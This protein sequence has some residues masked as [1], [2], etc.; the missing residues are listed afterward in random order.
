MEQLV[1]DPGLSDAT[2]AEAQGYLDTL[3][4]HGDVYS[5]T[6]VGIES[7]RFG[8]AKL[9]RTANRERRARAETPGTHFGP[10]ISGGEGS[11]SLGGGVGDFPEAQNF[12]GFGVNI[13]VA[14]FNESGIPASDLLPKDKAVPGGT[15]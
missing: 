8:A 4:A 5:V 12:G 11:A 1:G 3:R 6:G 15:E 2:R 7:T 10:P 13:G 9:I 14:F